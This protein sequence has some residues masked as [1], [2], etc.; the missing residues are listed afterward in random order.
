MEN[1]EKRLGESQQKLKIKRARIFAEADKRCK[2]EG[3]VG[4]TASELVDVG[5]RGIIR[6]LY[7][8]LSRKLPWVKWVGDYGED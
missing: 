3:F 1:F 8:K 2:K 6:K 7:R 5:R 4:V